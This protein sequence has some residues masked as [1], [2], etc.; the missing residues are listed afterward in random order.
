MVMLFAVVTGLESDAE[1]TARI[2]I[3]GTADV[4]SSV[5]EEAALRK[6]LSFRSFLRIFAVIRESEQ[7]EIG[8]AA[9]DG[10]GDV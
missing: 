1:I 6:C 7:T 2:A 8:Q 10:A 5:R 9:A 4:D 3:V